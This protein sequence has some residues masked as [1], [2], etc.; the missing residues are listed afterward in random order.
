MQETRQKHNPEKMIECYIDAYEEM[1][2]GIPLRTI[3]RVQEPNVA[4]YTS[5]FPEQVPPT[6]RWKSLRYTSGQTH[7]PFKWPKPAIDADPGDGV[8]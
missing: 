1:S 2:N 3:E 8:Q 6:P 7:R 4:D 5:P